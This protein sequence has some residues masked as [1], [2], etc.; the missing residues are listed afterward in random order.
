MKFLGIGDEILAYCKLRICS[1]FAA[2]A[3]CLA[4]VYCARASQTPSI[5][6]NSYHVHAQTKSSRQGRKDTAV[7]NTTDPN[8]TQSITTSSITASRQ[9]AV[10]LKDGILTIKANN[11]DLG[12]ILKQVANVSGMIISGPIKSARVFGI[13][14][15]R[16]PCDVLTDLLT[17]SGYNFIML[18]VTH[19]GAPRELLLTLQNGDSEHI[20]ASSRNVA[21]VDPS[22]NSDINAPDQDHLGP[23]AIVH[24]PPV[25]PQDP[26]ER[27]Q[28]KLQ[29]LEK[30][31]DQLNR[32]Q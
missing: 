11:S 4:N 9:A 26:Q 6:P 22:D 28:Q 24:V 14:G 7:T 1:R 8:Q 15:P 32:P 12:E 29:R 21:A 19:E 31:R 18:G 3:L 20:T 27:V 30:M 17:G 23:G 10:T 13:Y 25:P 16:N 5:P 2:C